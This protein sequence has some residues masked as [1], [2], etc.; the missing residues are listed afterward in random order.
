[1][2]PVREQRVADDGSFVEDG[3]GSAKVD[4]RMCWSWRLS[5]NVWMWQLEGYTVILVVCSA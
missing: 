5:A 1:M 2:D 3:S 4:V